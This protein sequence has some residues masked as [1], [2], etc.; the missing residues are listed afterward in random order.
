MAKKLIFPIR[1][2]GSDAPATEVAEL[3]TWAGS[4]SGKGG[5]LL[6]FRLEKSL[7]PQIDS[8]I[9][10]TCAGGP[11]YEER[12]LECTRGVQEGL[13]TAELWLDPGLVRGDGKSLRTLSPGTWCA[14]P[15]PSLLN[16]RNQYYSD[17]ED[18]LHALCSHYQGI[19]REMR[20]QGIAGHVLL[21]DRADVEEI[22]R[23]SGRKTF[24]YLTN[25]DEDSLSI[26][27]ENQRDVAVRSGDLDLIA[28]LSD[29]FRIGTVA[30]CDPDPGSL[31][32]LME[33]R[34]RD[35]VMVGGYCREKCQEYWK[36][37][38]GSAIL[39]L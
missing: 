13:I 28:G 15:A 35:Q 16:L 36:S 11:F 2:F 18:A 17:D 6:L 32:R 33:W 8:G 20:D 30:L 24:F 19:M 4:R 3:S 27:L 29:K 7:V 14:I 34:D 21:A 10:M 9:G 37:L 38:V 31:K 5:D 39:T 26:L 25:N 22:E 12:I 1:S 23:L